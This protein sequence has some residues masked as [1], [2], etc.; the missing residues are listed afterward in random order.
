MT[1]TFMRLVNEVYLETEYYS[2]SAFLGFA[3]AFG[4]ESTGFAAVV[5]F[6]AGADFGLWVGV[7]VFLSPY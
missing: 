6:L 4:L 3:G 1:A 2:E 7:A 5:A